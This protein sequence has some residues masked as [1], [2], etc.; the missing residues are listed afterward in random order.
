MVEPLL[1]HK[2]TNKIYD[3]ASHYSKLHFPLHSTV[4]I[5]NEEIESIRSYS[6][7]F[8]P[9]FFLGIFKIYIVEI[10]SKEGKILKIPFYASEKE[11]S[12]I[13]NKILQL[14]NPKIL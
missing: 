12:A 3:V 6:T 7:F 2:P 13:S 11:A 4:T 10:Y 9:G 5:R 1:C 8:L 14:I